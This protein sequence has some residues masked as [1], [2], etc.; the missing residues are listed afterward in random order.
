M[1]NASDVAARKYDA[2][3][4]PLHIRARNSWLYYLLYL[5]NT[6]LRDMTLFRELLNKYQHPYRLT[7]GA[8]LKVAGDA[9]QETQRIR[10]KV[11]FDLA[12]ARDS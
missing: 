9:H 1:V 8:P 11:L 4:V 7:I 2:P 10:D 3:V 6:E 5:L 12:R